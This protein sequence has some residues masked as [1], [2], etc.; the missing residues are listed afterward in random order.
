MEEEAV[1]FKAIHM[2]QMQWIGLSF[3]LPTREEIGSKDQDGVVQPNEKHHYW[4][5]RALVR[6]LRRH[7]LLRNPKSEWYNADTVENH[8]LQ[9]RYHGLVA[10]KWDYFQGCHDELDNKLAQL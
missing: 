8:P 1:R 3:P 5:G 2:T 6:W 7:K 4:Q 9:V 10:G